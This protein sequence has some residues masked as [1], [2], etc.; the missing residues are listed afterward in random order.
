MEMR[1]LVDTNII[2]G[3]ED[4]RVIDNSF[5]DF[6][7]YAVSNNCILY[8]YKGCIE[9]VSNDKDLD[10]RKAIL[11][12][13]K[14]YNVLPNPA[15]PTCDFVMTVGQKDE[16]DRID[17]EQL[18]QLYCGY[19]ELFVTEDKGIIK[20]ADK[21][22]VGHN[23]LS[24]AEALKKLRGKYE[25]KIPK[26]PILKHSSVRKIKEKK[27]DAFFH[28]LRQDYQGFDSWFDKCVKE[29]RSCY[30]LTIEGSL[31][32]LLIYNVEDVQQHKIPGIFE[33]AVKM[34][35]FKTNDNAFG[36]KT[37]ELFLHKM[38]EYCIER[39]INYLYL[40]LFDKYKFLVGLLTK[41]G[42]RESGENDRVERIMV[43]SLKKEDT[44]SPKPNQFSYH[45]FYCDSRHIAKF[46]IPIR[47]A[48]YNSLF[49]D[50]SLRQPTLFD[51]MEES[52]NEIQGNSIVKAYICN[53]KTKQL[54]TGDLL[55]FY[56]SRH[57]KAIQPIGVL[58]K[59]YTINRFENLLS[60]VRG[61]TVFSDEELLKM[62]EESLGTLTV[63][64]FRLVYYLKR[65]IELKTIKTLQCFKNRF[66]TITK[67][68]EKD[69][70]F[71]KK[72]NYFDERYIIDQT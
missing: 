6:H 27:S 8:Y 56:S 26:H 60:V 62:F 13:I 24:I 38:F 49:K 69:Y 53:A 33:R 50:S 57:L 3:L 66:I 46:V 20:N 22:G 37:G 52:L 72:E 2:I 51:N 36:L 42:F 16:N 4:H 12:K 18:F 14:K 70:L 5:S 48:F 32:A 68:P 40:T 67:M 58:E 28:S 29:D 11:S 44:T 64:V 10:R 31:A 15:K 25:Y 1:I 7:R 61:K 65:P 30:I 23:V 43:K 55:F 9:D 17:N 45:P 35:T 63:I 71:L 59:F 41:F 19:V 34:C 39:E 47:Q 54:K 21:I